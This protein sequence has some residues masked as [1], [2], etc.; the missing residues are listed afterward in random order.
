MEHHE[1]CDTNDFNLEGIKKPCN[2]GAISGSSPL[3]C[4]LPAPDEPQWLLFFEDGAV[5]EIYTDET[6]ARRRFKAAALTYAVHLYK[7]VDS[8]Q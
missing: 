6:A 8:Q 4:S 7:R 3:P 2:C 1:Y 5:T